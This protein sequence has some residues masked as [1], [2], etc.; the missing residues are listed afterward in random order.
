MSWSV[1]SI[2]SLIVVVLSVVSEG[3]LVFALSQTDFVLIGF[4]VL[5]LLISCFHWLGPL[6]VRWFGGCPWAVRP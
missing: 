4:L 5:L 6:L 3:S 2:S 1:C